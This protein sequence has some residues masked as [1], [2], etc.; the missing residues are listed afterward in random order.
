MANENF[1]NSSQPVIKIFNLEKR[2][3][4]Q[5]KV[6]EL[7]DQSYKRVKKNPLLNLI[8]SININMYNEEFSSLLFTQDSIFVRFHFRKLKNEL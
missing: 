4:S 8:K 1:G 3:E 7:N 2:N 6:F 5:T